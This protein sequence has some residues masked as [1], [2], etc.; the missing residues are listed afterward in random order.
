[1]PWNEGDLLLTGT[2]GI[3]PLT[4][5]DHVEASLLYEGKIQASIK[6]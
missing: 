3:K 4:H 5:G 6:T 1:M 2:P